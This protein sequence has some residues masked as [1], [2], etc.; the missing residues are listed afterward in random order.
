[1]W[2]ALSQSRRE[3]LR[4]SPEFFCMKFSIIFLRQKIIKCKKLLWNH[5]NKSTNL[6]KE[7]LSTSGDEWWKYFKLHFRPLFNTKVK[8]HKTE[9]T[10]YRQSRLNFLHKCLPDNGKCYENANTWSKYE[11]LELTFFILLFTLLFVLPHKI[12]FHSASWN[13]EGKWSANREDIGEENW[14]IWRL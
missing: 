12:F 4:I 3:F 9:P 10:K 11:A 7:F 2:V 6:S 5:L 8:R 1:M 13:K 14:K